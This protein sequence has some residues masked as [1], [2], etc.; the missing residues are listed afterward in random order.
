MSKS[1]DID[2]SNNET[3][4]YVNISHIAITNGSS[5]SLIGKGRY[6]DNDIYLKIFTN[7]KSTGLLYEKKVYE[8]LLIKFEEKNIDIINFFIKPLKT[9]EIDY[10]PG[11]KSSYLKKLITIL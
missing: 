2:I 8:Y 4:D 7:S 5:N 6:N 9:F 11:N 1:K 3:P 10:D